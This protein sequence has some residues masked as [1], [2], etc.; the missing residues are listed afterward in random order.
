M[1]FDLP[2]CTVIT[3]HEASPL[4]PLSG[5]NNNDNLL[6]NKISLG[7]SSY[8]GN[9]GKAILMDS[10]QHARMNV[11]PLSVDVNKN[12]VLSVSFNLPSRPFSPTIKCNGI[13]PIS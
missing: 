10:E 4:L 6:Q 8:F 5:P 3:D 1:P 9:P 11:E 2:L 13:S 12:L 7:F